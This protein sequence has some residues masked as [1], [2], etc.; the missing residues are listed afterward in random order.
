MRARLDEGTGAPVVTPFARQ[1][2]ALL[3]VL[4]AADALLLRPAGDGARRAGD[5]VEFLPL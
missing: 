3:S 4:C 2:S 1:D 5:N